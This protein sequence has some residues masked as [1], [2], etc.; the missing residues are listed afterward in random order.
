M[1]QAI[2]GVFEG[3]LENMDWMD[4]ET[5]SYAKLKVNFILFHMILFV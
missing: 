4:D 2:K 5:R 3:N 1:I